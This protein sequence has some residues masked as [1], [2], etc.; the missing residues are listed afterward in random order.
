LHQETRLRPTFVGEQLRNIFSRIVCSTVVR[1][2]DFACELAGFVLSDVDGFE[3]IRFFPSGKVMAEVEKFF[4]L[5]Y[6]L[7]MRRELGMLCSFGF[8]STYCRSNLSGARLIIRFDLSLCPV[9]D[10]SLPD[11]METS[12]KHIFQRFDMDTDLSSRE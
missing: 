10:F 1:R 3:F 9:F 6:E 5:L 11:K 12:W 7:E 2:R 8:D 4:C